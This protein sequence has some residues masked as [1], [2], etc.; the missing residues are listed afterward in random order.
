VD[1]SVIFW[2]ARLVVAGIGFVLMYS[3]IRLLG[4]ARAAASWPTAPP[5]PALARPLGWAGIV[6]GLTILA[7]AAALSV[8]ELAGPAPVPG[9]QPWRSW[10]LAAVGA[11]VVVL[12]GSGVAGPLVNRAEIAVLIRTRGQEQRQPPPAPA[13]RTGD[14]DPALPDDGAAGWVYEDGVGGWYLAVATGTGQRL[15]RLRD[16]TLVPVGTAVPPLTLRGS[17]E[18]SVYPVVVP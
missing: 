17:V 7:A 5:V 11:L 9:T 6:A 4:R 10:L 12:V 15:L 3:A 14:V 18:I 16:F 2:A 13:P 8:A 1:H